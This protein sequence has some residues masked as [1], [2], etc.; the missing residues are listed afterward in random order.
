MERERGRQGDRAIER[1]RVTAINFDGQTFKYTCMYIHIMLDYTNKS[2]M[3][4]YTSKTLCTYVLTYL[5]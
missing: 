5:L 2:I 3:S 4:M 1:G